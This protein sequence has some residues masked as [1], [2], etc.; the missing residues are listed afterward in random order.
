MEQEEAAK[1]AAE[2]TEAQ[3]EA[4]IETAANQKLASFL[5]LIC[6]PPEGLDLN[7]SAVPS[8][9]IHVPDRSDAPPRK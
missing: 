2:Q 6:P 8:G 4:A 9:P 3:T 7:L 5:N 1:Q